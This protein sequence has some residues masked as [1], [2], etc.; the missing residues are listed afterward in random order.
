LASQPQ[1]VQSPDTTKQFPSFDTPEASTSVSSSPQRV[2]NR[3]GL[4]NLLRMDNM[5]HGKA[6]SPPNIDNITETATY[7]RTVKTFKENTG[8]DVNDRAAVAKW[9]KT[10]SNVKLG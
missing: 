1:L 9:V 5:L 8:I 7:K 2:K 4:R 3:R 6:L 10:N